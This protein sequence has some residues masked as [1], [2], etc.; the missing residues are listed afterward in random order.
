MP[1]TDTE[2]KQAGKPL[3]ALPAPSRLL[4]T[5]TT[6]EKME[7]NG[8]RTPPTTLT[9]DAR[10]HRARIVRHVLS[11][12][13]PALQVGEVE[14]WARAF[15]GALDAL[16]DAVA[17]GRWLAGVRRRRGERGVARMKT[18]TE[19][20]GDEGDADALTQLRA[21]STAPSAG[22]SGATHFVLCAA[23]AA[24][25]EDHA[26]R[27][28][29][30]PG[31]FALDDPAAVLY[32][33]DGWA[34]AYT[35]VGGTFTLASSSAYPALRTALRLA[36]YLHLTLLL[37]QHFLFDSG[38]N[39]VVSP[40]SGSLDLTPTSAST[41]TST[42][43]NTSTSSGTPTLTPT[44][45]RRFSFTAPLGLHSR[46]AHAH[47]PLTSSSTTPLPTNA[48][49]N[50]NSSAEAARE[51]F[52]TAL[53]RL[54]ST[55]PLL[56]S[57]AKVRWG[58]PSVVVGFAARER[59]HPPDAKEKAGRLTGDERAGL[60]SLIGWEARGAGEGANKE[61]EGESGNKLEAWA[62]RMHGASGFAR[63]QGLGVVLSRHVP[64]ESA[65]TTTMSTVSSSAAS[66]TSSSSTATSASSSTTSISSSSATPTP[67]ASSM[68]ASAA[69]SSPTPHDT[70][71]P[72][73]APF[74]TSYLF[75]SPASDT[76]LG[77][78]IRGLCARAEEPVEVRVAEDEGEGDIEGD[79]SAESRDKEGTEAASK[80]GAKAGGKEEGTEGEKGKVPDSA[81]SAD[82]S[83][84]ERKEEEQQEQEEE[85]ERIT[86]WLSCALCGAKTA[87]R[88]MS[89]GAFL[90]SYAKFLELL[91]YSS[92]VGALGEAVCVHTT[93]L[94]SSTSLS[95]SGSTS[96]SLATSDA[97][98][99]AALPPAR[100]HL[101]RHF[102]HKATR[103]V[104]SFALSKVQDVYEL[105]VPRVRILRGG[106]RASGGSEARN[107]FASAGAGKAGKA[108]DMASTGSSARS[109]L[110]SSYTAKEGGREG[111][112][113]KRALRR[114]IRA[115]W[116]GVG[117]CLER[118]ETVLVGS[119]LVGLRK[120]LPRLLRVRPRCAACRTRRNAREFAG[121]C[122]CA[123]CGV[124]SA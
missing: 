115:W 34:G 49:A 81:S 2:E 21:L 107:S 98:A 43:T 64:A 23:P 83:K 117:E 16:G 110:A 46:F 99:D 92:A 112:E 111:D 86:M 91:V 57:S 90:L 41:S 77:E 76:R 15:E 20:G 56:S 96:T 105:R 28:V 116:A 101:I 72:C 26:D 84:E 108:K 32:G 33:L 63:M 123:A 11:N 66:T 121:R 73:G 114:E 89:D 94:S 100:L 13:D 24:S 53:A 118:M 70:L 35:L 119:T 30:T 47:S 38:R 1:E 48:N 25:T 120:A 104:V 59:K 103:R 67:T 88:G 79:A 74:S 37:E 54:R 124:A 68:T 5:T 10:A 97:D 95:A 78:V 19:V 42:S 55:S 18:S 50:S 44:R 80:A 36:V 85:A 7:G 6:K 17:R 106:G 29:F 82:A 45:E 102:A 109:S 87:R 113:E 65:S 14:A 31:T 39:R 75:Y 69:S 58:A 40:R 60:N 51:P 27:C 122:A 12:A 62:E 61:K 52:S 71:A 3:S 22:S 8:N 4:T 9:A 93:S